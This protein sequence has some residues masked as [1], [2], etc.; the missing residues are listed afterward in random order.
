MIGRMTRR[1]LEEID[2]HCAAYASGQSPAQYVA[3]DDLSAAGPELAAALR[4]EMDH[5]ALLEQQLAACESGR[6]IA[7]GIAIDARID[8]LDVVQKC[9]AEGHTLASAVTRLNAA[10]PPVARALRQRVAELEQR[11]DKDAQAYSFTRE[12]CEIFGWQGGTIHQVLAEVT[13]LRRFEADHQA[14]DCPCCGEDA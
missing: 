4:A 13:R 6:D 8:A 1:R 7:R 3:A 5:A 11:L 14:D 10:L 2:G 9:Q 12:L